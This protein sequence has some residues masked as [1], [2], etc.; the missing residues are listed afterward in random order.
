MFASSAMV[1]CPDLHVYER[2]WLGQLSVDEMEGLSRHL[3]GCSSC[4]AAVQ[5]LH[6]RDTLLEPMQSDS[7]EAQ[8]IDAAIQAM[9]ER[10]KNLPVR[11][12]PTA[13]KSDWP[14]ASSTS[15]DSS[16]SSTP[17]LDFLT[18][19]QGPGELGRLGSYRVLKLVGQG[20]M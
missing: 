13:N 3:E 11:E 20:G 18:A 8:P 9:M 19:P 10:L 1:S 16:A 4:S 7:A 12:E 5:T 2:M 15:A 14:T 6:C 17:I